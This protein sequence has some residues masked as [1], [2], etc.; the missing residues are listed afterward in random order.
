MAFGSRVDARIG[1]VLSPTDGT[2]MGMEMAFLTPQVWVSPAAPAAASVLTANTGTQLVNTVNMVLDYATI[3]SLVLSGS[4]AISVTITGR[5]VDSVPITET[6][7]TNGT[8]PV[9]TLQAFKTVYVITI[10]FLPNRTLSVGESGTFGLF[11][12]TTDE[13]LVV[14]TVDGVAP[15]TPGVITAGSAT[16]GQEPRGTYTPNDV[17]NGART[18]KIVYLASRID[19]NAGV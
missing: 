15:G 16:P 8:T 18:Y 4:G 14:E 6:V 5:G 13:V 7:V 10:A 12:P 3:L 9:N 1:G 11:M 19:T 17:P 2:L